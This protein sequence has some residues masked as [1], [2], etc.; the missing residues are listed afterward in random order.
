LESNRQKSDERQRLES[1]FCHSIHAVTDILPHRQDL[2]YLCGRFAVEAVMP[3]TGGGPLEKVY[4]FLSLYLSSAKGRDIN[5]S[6]PRS[7]RQKK[8][9][10][11]TARFTSAPFSATRGPLYSRFQRFFGEQLFPRRRLV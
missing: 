7:F 11:L 1:V 8:F 4:S 6:S 9:L 3:A 2:Q 5:T 10:A